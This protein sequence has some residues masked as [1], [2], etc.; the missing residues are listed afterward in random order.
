MSNTERISTVVSEAPL[1]H[2]CEAA[3]EIWFSERAQEIA[4]AKRAC[5]FCPVRAECVKLGENEEFGVWGGMTAEEIRHAKRL[6]AAQLEEQ[7]NGRIFLMQKAGMS[8]SAMAR[9]LGIARKTLADRLNK[10]TAIAA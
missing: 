10:K 5:G 6:R 9:E 7:V 2:P 4:E 3:P 1:P 8:V